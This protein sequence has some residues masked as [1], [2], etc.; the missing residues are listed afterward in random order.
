MVA[1]V[2][3]LQ[4]GRNSI[5]RMRAL[6]GIRRRQKCFAP[7][8][9]EKIMATIKVPFRY[10][11]GSIKELNISPTTTVA[12]LKAQLGVRAY[13]AQNRRRHCCSVCSTLL[14]VLLACSAGFEPHFGWR[15][16]G[17]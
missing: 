17:G 3:R 13:Y 8:F 6:W 11:D 4:M 2:E 5:W 9:W 12:D 7:A 10:T 14:P 1:A 16:N 15:Q